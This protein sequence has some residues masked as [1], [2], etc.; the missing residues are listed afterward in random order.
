MR[1][2]GLNHDRTQGSVQVRTTRP[3]FS[4]FTYAVNRT[5]LLSHLRCL[6]ARCWPPPRGPSSG[7]CAPT[8]FLRVCIRHVTESA[9]SHGTSRLTFLTTP[10]ASMLRVKDAPPL[11]SLLPSSTVQQTGT[12]TCSTLFPSPRLPTQRITRKGKKRRRQLMVHILIPPLPPG[13][14][15]SDDAHEQQLRTC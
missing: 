10:G 15:K 9:S 2:G 6:N 3:P 8:H 1:V 13:T 4:V 7:V 11:P 5:G 12:L 14:R